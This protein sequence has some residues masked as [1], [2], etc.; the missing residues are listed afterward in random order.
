MKS[1]DKNLLQQKAVACPETQ[2]H[3]QR[4]V[5]FVLSHQHGMPSLVPD[6]TGQLHD[7]MGDTMNVMEVE[8]NGLAHAGAEKGNRTE[9]PKIVTRTSAG[10]L[11]EGDDPRGR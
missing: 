1:G 5:D 11:G 10:P 6:V 9:V 4:P 3:F 8:L 7:A 2:I